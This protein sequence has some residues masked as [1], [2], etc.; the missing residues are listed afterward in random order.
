MQVKLTWSYATS[1]AATL[2]TQL[3]IKHKLT[4]AAA[5]TYVTQ[6]TITN[7]SSVCNT[8][9]GTCEYLYPEG[10]LSN[11]VSYDFIVVTS[12]GSAGSPVESSVVTKINVI[13]PN[14]TVSSSQSSVSYTFPGATGTSVT[15]YKVELLAN[16]DSLIEDDGIIT[17]A[18]T[19]SGTFAAT[20]TAN[21]AYKVRV[22][23]KS[24]SADKV[25]LF[26]ISTT[27]TP[28]CNGASNLQACICGVDCASAC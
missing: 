23:V 11:N 19:I 9:T 22:T 28:P 25:C 6:A 27:S 3:V 8:T 20:L 18:S 13:C 5:N 7:I 2:P 21:T 4:G 17:V 14:V 1:P 16:N 26:P 24:S 12:C 10:V 15:G